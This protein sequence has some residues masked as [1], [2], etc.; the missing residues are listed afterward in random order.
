MITIITNKH[1]ETNDIQLIMDIIMRR[2]SITTASQRS[3]LS[4]Y[5]IMKLIKERIGP[6][7]A[8]NKRQMVMYK[9]HNLIY[10]DHN[11]SAAVL[12]YNNKKSSLIGQTDYDLSPDHADAYTALDQA[13][14]KSRT[15]RRE[16]DTIFHKDLGFVSAIADVYPLYNQHHDCLGV[17]LC[18]DVTLQLSKQPFSVVLQY[19]SKGC[20]HY[21]IR[22][23]SYK[24][25]SLYSSNLVLY[26]REVECL[27]Y[28]SIGLTSKTIA[29]HMRISPRTIDDMTS[30][31]KDKFG[32]YSRQMLID[33]VIAC[34][35]FTELL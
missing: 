7:F 35:L 31:L 15:H 10:R 33:H 28:L 13:V 16:Q 25:S 19:L 1:N 34:E 18:G 22:K 12:G 32:V 2:C 17:V 5:E 29:Q 30:R 20:A 26:R 21:F 11:Q 3:N 9:D 6:G 4:N 14:I 27:L 23:N 8:N 24:I